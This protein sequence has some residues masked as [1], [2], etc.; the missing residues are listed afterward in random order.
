M[1]CAYQL[2]GAEVLLEFYTDETAKIHL[3]WKDI[4]GD[5]YDLTGYTGTGY[6]L[7]ADGA[8]AADWPLTLAAASPNIDATIDATDLAGLAVGCY[9]LRLKLSSGGEIYYMPDGGTLRIS[10]KEAL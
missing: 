3:D 6:L 5:V 10:I 2:E 4:A 1:S 7:D 9:T 8:T